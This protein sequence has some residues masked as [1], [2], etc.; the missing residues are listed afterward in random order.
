MV[1]HRWPAGCETTTVRCG[2][3][4]SAKWVSAGREQMGSV[5]EIGAKR[6]VVARETLVPE[7]VR[8]T[9]LVNNGQ[10]YSRCGFKVSG[11]F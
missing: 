11:V 4:K 7:E 9:V 1:A 3:M 6:T 5:V 2:V 8:G 10:R